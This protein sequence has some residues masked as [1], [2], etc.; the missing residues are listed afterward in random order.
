MKSRLPAGMLAGVLV[1]GLS[2]CFALRGFEWSKQQPKAGTTVVAKLTVGPALIPGPPGV[3]GYSHKDYPFTLIG[4][5]SSGNFTLGTGSRWDTEGH[6]NG[7]KPLI[8]DQSL[9]DFVL[10]NGNCDITDY[11]T[12][13][14][15]LDTQ[16]YIWKAVRPEAL[17]GDKGKIAKTAL[18]K[19]KIK[20]DNG[21]QTDVDN[22]VFV[23]GEWVD[24]GDTTPEDS[25][26]IQC[27]GQLNAS[28]ATKPG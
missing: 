2:G 5:S 27:N 14:V 23:T 13:T 1:L 15:P 6:F 10:S 18:E 3:G 9:A 16:A 12:N 4:F 8:P 17:V 19:I 25:D 28:I 21:A 11:T 26:T 7:P 24:D 22:V 20:V